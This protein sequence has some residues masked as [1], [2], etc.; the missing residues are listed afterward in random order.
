VFKPIPGERY[1][2]IQL[3]TSD[4]LLRTGLPGSA[5]IPFP[6]RIT[7][8]CR[9]TVDR[10]FHRLVLRTTCIGKPHLIKYAY[11]PK[12]RSSVDVGLGTNGF[13]VLTPTTGTTVLDH[14]AG[15]ADWCGGILT[16]AT[17][18]VLAGC[19]RRSR[20]NSTSRH[21]KP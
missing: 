18:A 6:G 9:A 3:S 7:D 4:P 15:A 17:A 11:Y 21:A 10:A 13:M 19:Y 14:R 16:L 8:T 2:N 20:G 5:D 1:R 12:W